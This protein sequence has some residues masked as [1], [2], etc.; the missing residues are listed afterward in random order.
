MITLVSSVAFVVLLAVL[1]ARD[2]G[3]F[4][5]L[6]RKFLCLAPFF[7]LVSL[8]NHN[9]DNERW[10]TAVRVLPI[11]AA[12]VLLLLSLLLW[13]ARGAKLPLGGAGLCLLLYAALAALQIP[14]S[15]NPAWSLCAWSWSAPGYLLFLIAGRATPAE[16]L[17]RDK[18]FVWSL[19]GFNAISQGL[20]A[21]GLLTGRVDEL[22]HTRNLG[23]IYASNAMLMTVVL[24]AGLCWP[25]VRDSLGWCFT[26]LLVNV[27][28][29]VLSLS[30]TAIGV[31]AVYLA[32]MAGGGRGGRQRALRA[33]GLLALVLLSLFLVARQRLD[34]DTQLLASWSSR[35]AEGDYTAAYLDARGLRESKFEG[36][37]RAVWHDWPWHGQGI[38]TFLHFSQFSDAHDI[39]VTEAFENSLLAAIF[40]VLAYSLPQVARALFD[41]ALRGIAVSILGFLVLGQMTGAM[42]AY[43]SEGN[44]Y[45]AHPGWTL[46]YLIGVVSGQLRQ[47]S[48][49]VSPERAEPGLGLA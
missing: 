34:L 32:V 13:K 25:A 15:V 44:Y 37:H 11:Y 9:A 48:A 19:L 40:L 38:G 33:A 20:I 18:L 35:W 21:T 29:M 4:P 23:S 2:G 17:V 26:F 43:R 7:P 1:W 36:F 10:G 41:P 8:L 24:F 31:V 16:A 42:L 39:F 5:E 27:S 6:A 45:T 49:A 22:F 3:S 47:R 12:L 14:G 30:R 28:S 46:F